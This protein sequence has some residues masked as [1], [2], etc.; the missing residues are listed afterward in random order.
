MFLLTVWIRTLPATPLK[1]WLPPTTLS[2]R[3]CRP[4]LPLTA[5]SPKPPTSPLKCAIAWHFSLPRC[6]CLQSVRS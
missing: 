3:S 4:M 6:P 5:M 1:L 2:L